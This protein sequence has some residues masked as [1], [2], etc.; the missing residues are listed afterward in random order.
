MVVCGLANWTRSLV[1]DAR[2]SKSERKR[3]QHALQALGERLIGL[4]ADVRAT[5]ALDERLIEAIDDL[6]RMKSHEAIRRQKQFIGRLMRDADETRI[7]EFFAQRDA[8][9][10]REK[11]RFTLAERWRDRLLREGGDAL[12]AF[13]AE[14]GADPS[15]IAAVL[16][17]LAAA[18]SDAHERG[19]KRQLFRE[20]HGALAAGSRDS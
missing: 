12:P 10:Q 17:D 3:Q 19:L 13:A 14:T 1:D 11:R 9:E 16:A 15:A 8:E 2:P 7:R 4:P 6:G 5:L 18:H 20:V